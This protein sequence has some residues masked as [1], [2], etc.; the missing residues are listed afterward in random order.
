MQ[1]DKKAVYLLSEQPA[2]VGS[3]TFLLEHEGYQVLPINGPSAF[4]STHNSVLVF[5]CPE[6]GSR[7]IQS[8]EIANPVSCG[9]PTIVISDDTAPG[10]IFRAFGNGVADYVFKPFAKKELMSSIER[11]DSKTVVKRQSLPPLADLKTRI[12]S[13]QS[14]LLSLL[15]E[16]H[17]QKSICE[18]LGLEQSNLEERIAALL[19]EF[20]EESIARLT[21]HVCRTHQLS[22]IGS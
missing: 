6:R 1:G 11:V 20:E 19:E 12:G 10:S 8:G 5:D 18:K 14:A 22:T 13:N 17:S 15:L 7:R 2:I 3:V 21:R 4:V 9:P 16:G